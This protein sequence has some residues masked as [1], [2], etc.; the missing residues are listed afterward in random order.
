MSRKIRVVIRLA[1]INTFSTSRRGNVQGD[2]L[3]ARGLEKYLQRHPRVDWARCIGPSDRVPARADAVIHFNPFLD[4]TT[5]VK[6]ILYL[7]N[8]FPKE[9]YPG[10]TV[11]VFES[12]RSRYDGFIFTSE[13]LMKCCAPGAVIPF[14]T[15]PEVFQPK[16]E[17]RLE[18][19][20]TFVGNNIRKA[21]V[22][23]RYFSPAIQFGLV[24][25]GNEIGWPDPFYDCCR[26]KLPM[27]DLPSLYSSCKI[28]LNAHIAEHVEMDTVNLRLFDILACGG[29]VMSDR[30][31]SLESFF[32]DSVPATEGG[33]DLW[34]QLVLFLSDTAERQRRSVLGRKVVMRSHTYAHRIETLMNFFDDTL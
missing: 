19:A 9:A 31:A 34:A 23:N 15:D 18:H 16:Y 1:G 4:V 3:I 20:V 30:I 13:R 26:G 12:V 21:R 33:E 27:A 7:Q 29:F 8:A 25:Y 22:N 2:E 5:G 28:N 11:G 17:P 10:G 32:E 24:I 14:A 6:N